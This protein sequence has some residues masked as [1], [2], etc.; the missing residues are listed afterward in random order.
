MSELFPCNKCQKM[1]TKDEGGNVFTV[2]DDCWE[3]EK[4]SIKKQ[5]H[6]TQYQIQPMEFIGKNNIGYIEGNIIKYVCRYKLKNGIE[7]L[8]KAAHYLE[9]LIERETNGDITLGDKANENGSNK[10]TRCTMGEVDQA[11]IRG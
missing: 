4:H 1:R 5:K 6:Y 8:H 10:E 7:D 2:C 3:K 11:S 9:K